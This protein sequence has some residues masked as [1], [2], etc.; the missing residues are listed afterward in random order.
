[1]R[2]AVLNRRGKM[3]RLLFVELF[4]YAQPGGDILPPAVTAR[5]RQS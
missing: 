3:P 2:R 5:I 4:F 1:M